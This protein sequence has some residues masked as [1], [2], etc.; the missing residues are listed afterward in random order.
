MKE[1]KRLERLERLERFERERSD[2]SSRFIVSPAL[3]A[4][5]R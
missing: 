2:I 3:A 1:E 5:D 4:G